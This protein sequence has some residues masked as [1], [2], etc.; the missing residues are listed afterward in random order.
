ML[1]E[2]DGAV[3][4]NAEARKY[5]LD[6]GLS[7]G[8][9]TSGDILAL[10][11]MINKEL[12]ISNK[13]NET[14]ANMQLSE[15]IDINCKSNGSI[16]S[17]FIYLNSH[18]FTRRE[19]VSFNRDGFIGFAGWADQGNLNPILRAFLKWCDCMKEVKGNDDGREN[20]A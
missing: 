11:L 16:I 1:R 15:K 5:F 19:C 9:I 10:I 6:C 12:R 18:Y 13:R 20:E 7:Y 3:C 14:S 17:C 4:T 2:I 8:D